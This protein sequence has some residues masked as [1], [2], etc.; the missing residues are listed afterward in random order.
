MFLKKDSLILGLVLGF[1]APLLGLLVFYFLKFSSISFWEYLQ[2]LVSAKSFFTSVITVSLIA[3]GAIFTIYT[4]SGRDETARGIF[5]ATCIY[6]I[7]S[8]GLKFVG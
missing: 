1:L 6:A 5:I 2:V 4:N 8:I 7:I 3:D